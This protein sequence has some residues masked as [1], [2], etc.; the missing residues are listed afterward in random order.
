[1]IKLGILEA[2]QNRPQFI[3]NHGTMGDWFVPFLNQ[4]EKEWS[5]K[6]YKA[7]LGHLPGS[8]HE[9]SAYLITGSAHSVYE[10]MDWLDK[11]SRF[12]RVSADQVPIVGIC[13][14]HQLLHHIFGG[15]V[16]ASKIGWCIG[17]H[18]YDVFQQLEWMHPSVSQFNLIASHKDQVIEPAKGAHILAGSSFCP[19][20]ASTIGENILTIQP[21]P[22]IDKELAK[23]IYELRRDE[24]G[25]DV[26][27]RAL[28]TMDRKID[29]DIV[30]EWITNFLYS[31]L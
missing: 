16:C 10:K 27:D 9:C 2:G 26:T 24:Q 7:Y 11:L 22:E 25:A 28:S 29:D 1:M 12:I 15:M 3:D 17:V 14:G 13:F 18:E 4:V 6:F 30:A 19:V 5:F 21:H 8:A 31:R 20:A 23:L